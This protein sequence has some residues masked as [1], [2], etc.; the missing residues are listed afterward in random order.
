MKKIKVLILML[1]LAIALSFTGCEILESLTDSDPQY[2]GGV[3]EGPSNSG[4]VGNDEN[5]DEANNNENGNG[6]N[7]V[8]DNDSSGSEP[9][10]VH[11]YKTFSTTEA[12]CYSEGSEIKK[13]ECGD[14]VS[15]TIP[16]TSHTSEIIPATDKATE[17]KRCSVCKVI[18]VKPEPI[19]SSDFETPSKYDGDYAYN[20]LLS[21][22]N[23]EKLT[24]LYNLIDNI[25][26]EFHVSGEDA[27]ENGVIGQIDYSDIG[28][29]TSDAVAVWSAYQMDHPVYYW[30]SK[31]VSYTSKEII[32]SAAQDYV[33]GD[34]RDSLNEKIYS[35]V[36]AIVGEINSESEYIIALTLHDLIIG[37][38]DYAY[39]PDGV[40][41]SDAVSAHNIIGLIDKGE[42][43][44]E[45]YAKTF[46]LMLNFC[47]IENVLVAGYAGEAHAWNMAKLDDGEWY[48]FDLTWDDTPDFAF[49]VSH[50]YF[51]VNDSEPLLGLDGPWVTAESSFAANHSPYIA[52]N[53]GIDFNYTLPARS[54][55]PFNSSDALLRSVFKVDQLSY[56][57]TGANT[58]C[59][60]KIESAGAVVVPETVSYGGIE[61]KVTSIGRIEGKLFKTGSLVAEYYTPYGELT[62][63][64]T[65]ISIPK[66]VDL[67]WDD[68][69]NIHSLTDIT[70]DNGNTVYASLDGVLYTKDL[71][72]LVKYPSGR[73][74]KI[75]TLPE[76]C[77]AIAHGA[78]NMYFSNMEMALEK[79]IITGNDVTAG[80]AHY[81]YGYSNTENGN[82]IAGE[83]ETILKF[84]LGAGDIEYPA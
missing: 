48:W 34:V 68:A 83:W 24:N 76:E 10:H 3:S 50:R 67:I 27:G 7:N 62:M 49:G 18:L 22:N 43:V 23:G 60:V 6:S 38:G 63:E 26:D 59:L 13:C 69:L 64:I 8:G 21:L 20:Y 39:M 78:F 33:S 82:F 51:A 46:Q 44:C 55:S 30:F 5:K 15:E 1:V 41:P 47:D 29:S 19:F 79:I 71:S 12:T 58:V 77:V 31:T 72:V 14:T 74:D 66:T 45:S 11:D 25:A 28:L 54:D 32:I 75:Y 17:G 81:G 80:I 61:Y 57:I 37:L 70:V 2:N 65:S 35:V 52:N 42:G 73:T 53:T 56:A 9:D 4:N 36:E 16:M 84:L 40:T